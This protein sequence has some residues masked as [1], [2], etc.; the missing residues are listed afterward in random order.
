MELDIALYNLSSG[1]GVITS[2]QLSLQPGTANRK[3][4]NVAAGE[5][6]REENPENSKAISGKN[7]NISVT[8]VFFSITCGSIK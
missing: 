1:G 7:A 6:I 8:F 4:S 5:K 3:V 2:H